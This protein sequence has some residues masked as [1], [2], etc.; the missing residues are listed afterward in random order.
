MLELLGQRGEVREVIL[1]ALQGLALRP[2]LA[3]KE[4]GGGEEKGS[5]GRKGSWSL[6]APGD[7]DQHDDSDRES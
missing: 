2:N 5:G 4:G 1:L 3:R 6:C 7:S